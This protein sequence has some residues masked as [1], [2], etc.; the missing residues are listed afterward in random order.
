MLG[1]GE[2]LPAVVEGIEKFVEL[3]GAPTNQAARV[4]SD[5]GITFAF[6][7]LLQQPFHYGDIVHHAE[8]V[9]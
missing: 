4:L 8:E 3:A 9:L 7:Q 6:Q 1:L 5:F 2:L